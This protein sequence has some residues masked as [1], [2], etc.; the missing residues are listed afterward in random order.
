MARLRR[1]GAVVSTLNEWHGVSAHKPNGFRRDDEI[2]RFRLY[3]AMVKASA[4]SR[5]ALDVSRDIGLLDRL[6]S[7]ISLDDPLTTVN[8]VELF[9]MV[10]G[11][12]YV[13]LPC[14]CIAVRL[15]HSTAHLW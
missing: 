7:D 6:M 8:V 1:P 4:I 14:S 12:A 2:S 11:A 5:T 15:F 10:R 13:F 3:E 9:A